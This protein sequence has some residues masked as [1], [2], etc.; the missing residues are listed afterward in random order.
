MA[1]QCPKCQAEIGD[2][3][4]FCSKCGTP[5]H[6]SE[7]AFISQT[8]TI[9]EPME[10]RLPGTMLAGKYKIIE[11]L[12]R[13]GM[14]IV[15]KAEDTKLRRHVALKF[16]PPELIQ[17]E[18]A[19]ERFV[20]EARSAAALAHPNICTIHEIDEEDSR[21]FIAMECV[22]G[23]SLKEQI[24]QGSL[25]VEAALDVAT[26]VVEALGE[27]HKEGIVHRDIKS[28]NIMITSKGQAKVMDFG[29]A[30]VKGGTLMTREG[31]TL[32]TVAYMSPEQARGEE[33]DH[34]TDIW[35]L[36]VVLYEMLTG[37]L[38]F[39]G[40][41]E[42]SILYSVVHEEP[43]S[44]KD[45]K[46]DI[47]LEFQQIINR[48]LKKNREARYSSS[49]E[50]LNDLRKYQDRLRAE[51]LG[52]FNLRRLLRHIRR[53]QVAIPAICGIILIALASVWFVNRQA[54]IRWARGEILPQVEKMIVEN[55]VWRDLVP[56]YRLAKK[57]ESVLGEDPRLSELF[58]KC[59]LNIN[60]RTDPSGAS[61]YM[62]EYSHPESEWSFLGITPLE[63]IQVPIG[64]FR[65][66]MEKE[67]YKTVLSADST[68]DMTISQPGVVIPRDIVRMLDRE[69][70]LPPGMVRVSST[71]T[72]MGTLND[73][74][75]DRCEVTNKQYKAFVDAGGYRQ[76][77]FWQHP[78]IRDGRELTW[79]EARSEFVDQSGQTGPSTWLAGD[80]PQG[81][82]NYPVSGVSWYEA[83]AYAEFAGKS[84]PTSTHWDA[85]RG[86]FTPMI[87]WPQL[88]G[89]ALFAPFSNFEESGSVPVGSLQGLTAYG[90]LD[91]AGNVREWCWNEAPKGRII[92]GGAWGDNTYEFE[93]QR[94]A[95]PMDR[96]PK[97]GFRC[98]LYPN[99]ENTTEPVFGMIDPVEPVDLYKQTPVPDQVFQVYKEQFAYDRTDLNAEVEDRAGSPNG[100]IREKISFDAAYG[101]ERVILYLFL[102]KNAQP[103]FQTVIYAPADPCVLERSSQD[104]ESY[105]E[106]AIFL[107][108]LVKNGRAVI[109]PVC[110]GTFERGNDK[111]TAVYFLQQSSHQFRELFIQQTQDLKRSIDYLETRPDIDVEKLAFYGMCSSAALGAIIPAVEERLK[112]NV[113]VSGGLWDRGRSEVSQIN[114]ITRVTIP[115]LMLNG[116]FDVIFPLETSSRPMFELLGTPAEHKKHILYDT[117]H[118]P[119]R[120][121][122]IK[123]TLSWLDKYF[124]PV[125]R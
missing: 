48:A 78:F 20:L 122:F 92:R 24:K 32:G 37:E 6:S 50:M 23:Q 69:D 51:E 118:I 11:I 39:K 55:D 9:L 82:D 45:I 76:I 44:L 112:I 16:L 62:K 109:F 19:R 31:T 40:E 80:Y 14:G 110:K 83:A 59:A 65:W 67:G 84:L 77:K 68:W 7:N 47:P 94:Q 104:I 10:E 41:R 25:G 74:F 2:D 111:L 13:G 72:E 63:K 35:S 3:S 101:D 125:N 42:A 107:S 90:A 52:V 56:A 113:L 21:S 57:A 29:L 34:R 121:E 124:G 96:S 114:Y 60:V 123:E 93:H 99:Q 8:M 89:F 71:E 116:K 73:F 53:P 87:Q 18:E 79:E 86:A 28:A 100:W 43:K 88:G 97:N 105:Y 12:G 38:P 33:V 4:R 15:Y 102:P 36:G 27:A 119:P 70:Q 61:V 58:S 46:R 64:V 66:K 54:R 115:A 5:I 95:P 81:Q 108:H 49:E 17:D 26:Q 106:F 75:I 98:A 1:M 85:A 30:K 103:P 91:M 117:D 120:N 22:E